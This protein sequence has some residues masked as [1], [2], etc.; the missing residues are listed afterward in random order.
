MAAFTRTTAKSMTALLI[1]CVS[2]VSSV[3]LLAQH[4]DV[5]PPPGRLI[6][7]GGRTLH[8]NCT[9]SG[10]PTVVIE[11]GASSFALDFSLVQPEV[12]RTNRVCSYDRAGLGWSER[13]SQVDRPER[14]VSDLRAAL[15]ASGERPPYVMVG[16]SF[17]ALYV[18]LYQ[19]E[20]PDDVIG[21][22]LVDP[23]TEDRL[24]TLFEGRM[25]AIGALTAEQ[26][27]TTLPASGAVPNRAGARPPQ[28]G[29]PFDRLPKDLYETRIA[30][31]ERLIASQGTSVPAEIA[32][33]FA[34][35][36]RAMLARLLESRTAKAAPIRTTP[37]VVLT[38]GIGMTPGIAENHA[39]LASL[40]TNARHTVVPD[41]GHEIHLFAPSVVVQ[42]IRDVSAAARE[43]TRLPTRP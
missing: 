6:D 15:A 23:G 12:A 9:G 38:R 14:V 41:A 20:H 30:L 36:N 4:A 8:V 42:A 26:L 3:T 27:A 39:G 1:L 11:A 7:V 18:R 34:E 40:S 31:D 35:A 37:V 17:G 28:T 13:H 29:T 21:L 19:L 24:F 43:G 33:E 2:L 22:V 10:S 32:R 5:G 16:A 25:V